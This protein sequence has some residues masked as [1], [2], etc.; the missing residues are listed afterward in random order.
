MV[1]C[2][3]GTL[4]TCG[5]RAMLNCNNNGIESVKEGTLRPVP[6]VLIVNQAKSLVD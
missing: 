1:T 6:V 5:S 3:T 4:P 2:D